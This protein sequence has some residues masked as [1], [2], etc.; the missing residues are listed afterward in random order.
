MKV[1]NVSRHQFALLPIFVVLSL[2]LY[3][4]DAVAQKRCVKGK[5]CGNTCIAAYKT[6]HIGTQEKQGTVTRPTFGDPSPLNP[7]PRDPKSRATAPV[8]T[9]R[10]QKGSDIIIP[11]GTQYIGWIPGRIYYWAGC[12]AWKNL[13]A[14]DLVFFRT[15]DE[16]D[17]ARYIPS[18]MKGCAGPPTTNS[19]AVNMHASRDYNNSPG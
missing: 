5:P 3:A 9:Q 12:D 18:G 15:A 8:R 13:P 17:R 4:S 11:E 2:C 7:T 16:A 6:C 14:E 19:D 10:K 1:S